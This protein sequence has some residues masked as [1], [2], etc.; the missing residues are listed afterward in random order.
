MLRLKPLLQERALHQLSQTQW[1][2][3]QTA[4]TAPACALQLQDDQPIYHWLTLAQQRRAI[5]CRA[6]RQAAASRVRHNM[7]FR[8]LWAMLEAGRV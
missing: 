8:V 6:Q 3:R 7:G 4:D 5:V 1:Q 2:S